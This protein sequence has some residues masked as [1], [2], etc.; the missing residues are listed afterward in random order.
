MYQ[1]SISKSNRH[2]FIDK[3]N[4]ER[5]VEKEFSKVCDITDD[6]E[7]HYKLLNPETSKNRYSDIKPCIF[8]Y[9]TNR[10]LQHCSFINWEIYQCLLCSNPK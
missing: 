6:D 5:E 8:I 1:Q 4:G 7:K 2:V 9:I 3:V 10:Q